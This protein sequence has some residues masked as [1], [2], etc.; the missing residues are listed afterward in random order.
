MFRNFSRTD[1]HKGNCRAFPG[2]SKKFP[3]TFPRM[4]PA[5]KDK[6]I[7]FGRKAKHPTTLFFLQG[8]KKFSINSRMDGRYPIR[9]YTEADY[10][11]PYLL[12]CRDHIIR[13][14]KHRIGDRTI[15]PVCKRVD[16]CIIAMEFQD[17]GNIP[18]FQEGRDD[19][20][21]RDIFRLQDIG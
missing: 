7:G 11:L 21:V 17:K 12:T 4:Q 6:D 14:E 20:A 9:F 10:Y 2:D 5:D 16:P 1:K 18:P 8:I 3:D 19:A 13:P 15:D